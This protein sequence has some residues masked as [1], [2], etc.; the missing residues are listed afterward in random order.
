MTGPPGLILALIAL[1]ATLG[2]AISPN[3]RAREAVVAAVG[4]GVVVCVGASSLTGARH[5]LSGLGPT[6]GFLA[7]L[8]LLGEGCRREGVFDAI[9]GVLGARAGGDPRRLLG[10]VF[11]V[12]AGVTAVLSLDATVVLLTPVVLLSAR[13]LGTSAKPASYACA[14][15]ANSASLILPISNLTNLLAFSATGL[16]FSRFTGLMALPWAAALGVEWAVLRRVFRASLDRRPNPAG[17]VDPAGE[18]ARAPVFALAIVGLALAGFALSSVLR[19]EPV[20][21]AAGAAAAISARGLGRRSTSVAALVRAAEPGFLIFV[22]GLGVIVSAASADGLGSAVGDLLPGGSSLGD[23]LAIAGISGVLSNVLN[24]LPAT[25]IV[26]PIL[27]PA[28]PVAVLAALIGTNI[29]PNLTYV[30]SLAT[31][32]WRRVLRGEGVAVELGEFTRLGALTVPAA[33]V[34]STVGLWCGA[35]LLGQ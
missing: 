10:L 15:L 20:W 31:L 14:H 17:G 7:A 4:A 6:V 8:L 25:L 24:N 5:E 16:S 28:G 22:L 29:G 13:R 30:G 34:A 32:L 18:G 27:A 33:L 1:G 9:G 12:A 26:V 2:A 21:V 35:R 23:L 11:V 19:L 3:R